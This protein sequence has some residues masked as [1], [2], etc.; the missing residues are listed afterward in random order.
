M[1]VTA[2]SYAVDTSVCVCVCVFVCVC[3]CTCVCVCVCVCHSKSQDAS[4]GTSGVA[5]QVGS[6][7]EVVDSQEADEAAAQRAADDPNEAAR[8]KT[9]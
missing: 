2:S 8:R 5:A 9:R 4:A 3:V 7:A 6:I 1:H